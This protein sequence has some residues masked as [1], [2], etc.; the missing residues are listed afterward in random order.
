MK[1]GAGMRHAIAMIELIFAIVIIAISVLSIP[2][3]MAVADN[4]TKGMVIDEDLLKRMMG[5]ITKVSQARWDRNSTAPDFR[6]LRIAGDLQCDRADPL[7][8]EGWYRRNPDSSMM[9]ADNGPMMGTAPVNGDLN[10]SRGIE[11]LHNRSYNMEINATDGNI[12]TVP[13]QYRVSYVSAAISA[14]DADGVATAT[15]R[16]GSSTNLNPDA[17]GTAT[18]LKRVVVHSQDN[19]P[20][21]DMTLTF[22]K[23]NVGKFAE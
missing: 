23:S 18:H 6:P 13:I 2:S 16:V 20:D 1:K 9:C 3:M 22:F 21:I 17:S 8:G 12:Y 10:L 7:G 4:A 5:E 15:W 11:Q 19:D 14:I